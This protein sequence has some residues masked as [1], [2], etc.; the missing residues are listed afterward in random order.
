MSQGAI[1]TMKA[2]GLGISAK[3]TVAFVLIAAAV[4]VV[5]G[6]R[7]YQ[8][9]HAALESA[10]LIQMASVAGEKEGAINFWIENRRSDMAAF[11]ASPSLIESVAALFGAHADEARG[12]AMADLKLRVALD[13]T[14]LAFMVLDPDTGRVIASTDPSEE[15]KFK[16][17]RTF[18]L[19]G[20][21]A[22]T[23]EGM[24]YSIGVQGR[25]MAA[26]APLRSPEGRLL[27]VLAA[28]VDPSEVDVIVQ[29]RGGQR[30]T[31]DAFLVSPSSMFMSQPRLF[32]DPVVLRVSVRS[33]AITRL[34]AGG[35]GVISAPDY[36]GVPALIAYR[37]LPSIQGGLIVKI[38]QSEA[39]APL[40]ELR[41]TIL[42]VGSAVLLAAVLLA[43]W[44]SRI[45]SV[46]IRKLARGA[47]EIGEGKLDTRIAIRARDETGQL[48]KAFGQM[49]ENLQQTLV[50]KELLA[51]EVEERI[52][53]EE[54]LRE[55]S[56]YLLF[57]GKAVEAASDA[58]GISDAQGRHIYQN[59]A[60]SDL[61]E[62]ATAEEMQAA[63][64][65]MAV[66]RDPEVAKQMFGSIMNG[67][68]WSGELEMVTKNGRVFP[69]FERADAVTDSAGNIVGL[70]G[71]ARD[72]TE[73][74]LAEEALQRTEEQLR[75]SQKMESIG[76]LAGGIAHDFNN[77]LTAI[78]GYSQLTLTNLEGQS[79][80]LRA[81]VEQIQHAAERA[82]ALTGQ[83]LAFSRR[84]VLRPS[85]VSLNE[86]LDGLEPMLRR[87]L[88]ASIDLVSLR[89]PDLGCAEV[90]VHQF[91]QVLMNLALNARDAMPSGGR[92]TLET[93]NVELDEEYCRSHAG[94]TLG[95][96][97]M[98]AVSDNGIGMDEAT[99]ERV[100]EPFYTTKPPGAGTG[101]G[102]A[103]V[104]GIVKQSRGYINVY[105]ELG[106]GTAFKIYLPRVTPHETSVEMVPA[107]QPFSSGH[108]RVVV[109]EDESYLRSLVAR[110]LGDMGYEVVCFG[111]ADDAM[112][113][114]ESGQVVAELLLTDVV[115]PG[116]MQ[117]NDLVR[118]VH[119][120]RPDLPVLY[121][122]GYTRNAIVHAGRLDEGVNFL[123]KPF[124]PDALAR[125]VREVLDQGSASG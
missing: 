102:L 42:I 51:A 66:V 47:A 75:E 53:V 49:A 78:I 52:A 108:E 124:T 61:F 44:V 120:F 10:T 70:I 8:S 95:S 63:G 55:T 43:Y 33:E 110:V 125:M 26:S 46:P 82:S 69:A 16:E 6:V 77:L 64:G 118:K 65:G 79:E 60:S 80:G 93:A 1:A 3:I 91:E 5:L 121:M 30:T 116:T 39:F 17:N 100:F 104:Y 21:T 98:L 29:R 85:V 76:Q 34:L 13:S 59:K 62:Y 50:S 113:A 45:V 7:A 119:E 41:N 32:A 57:I 18:F 90:D 40:R 92:L 31:D 123:E 35:A 107:K 24:F 83:I 122:S 27:G 11:A 28:Y 84:Q 37:W 36:R 20:R 68:S 58:I 81:D 74:K 38:D 86:V 115:L 101:L 9:G 19:D 103:T 73:R 12:Q 25:A 109:V 105:S 22:P 71:I 56:E 106:K 97:V 72:I 111:S 2:R 54:H 89:H 96:C 4:I 117:G 15:G 67:G 23:V 114:L 99:L 87:T 88:G 112:V 94:A 48:A 14:Y